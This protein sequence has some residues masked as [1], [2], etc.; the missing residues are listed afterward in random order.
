MHDCIAYLFILLPQLRPVR[1]MVKLKT[2]KTKLFQDL[3]IF[4]SHLVSLGMID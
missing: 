3:K 2:E 1:N 4:T